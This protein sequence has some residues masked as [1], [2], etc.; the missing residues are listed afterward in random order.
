MN[1]IYCLVFNRSLGVLQAVAETARTHRA[2]GSSGGAAAPGRDPGRACLLGAT[3]L[4]GAL[5]LSLASPPAQGTTWTGSQSDDWSDPDNWTEGVPNPGTGA[6]IDTTGPNAPVLDG[7][8]SAANWLH[9]GT[10]SDGELTI[11]NG[12]ELF[13]QQ[14]ARLGGNPAVSGTVTVSG[15]GSTWTAWDF[16]HI[17]DAGQGWLTVDA[18]GTVSSS[19]TVLGLE[20]S[21]SGTGLVTGAGST[22]QNGTLTVGRWGEGELTVADGGA[23]SSTTAYIGEEIGGQGTVTVTG[24]DSTWTS[25]SLTVGRSG[26]GE[27]AVSD[28]G[29][30]SS[31]TGVVGSGVD[32]IGTATV[33]GTGSEWDSAML[34]VGQYGRGQVTI[35]DEGR[36]SSERGYIGGTAASTSHGTVTVSGVGSTWSNDFQLSVG[37]AGQGGLT[38]EAGGTV[39]SSQGT[40]GLSPG[41]RGT[42]TVSGSG[43]SWHSSGWLFIGRDGDGELTI[44]DGGTVASLHAVIADHGNST[45]KVTVT[46]NASTWVN[47]GDLDVGQ[48][49][50]GELV[51]D[52]GGT[53]TSVGA[54]IGNGANSRGA[55]LVTG[56]N[57]SWHN[58]SLSIGVEGDAVLTI[59]NGGTVHSS[60]SHVGLV[61]GGTGTV[62]VTGTD[63][64][65]E[66]GWLYLAS[67][68]EAALTI[69]DGGRVSTSNGAVGFQGTAS[70]L[71]T[72]PGSTWDTDGMYVG[73]SGE[74]ELSIANGGSVNADGGHVGLLAGSSGSLTVSGSASSFL[75]SGQLVVGQQ[76]NGEL[77]IANGGL[78]VSVNGTIGGHTGAIGTATINGIGSS[79]I[80]SGQF[81][82]G[83][84]GVGGLTIS[85][86]GMLDSGIAAVGNGAG[87]SGTVTVTG[88]GSTW[89]SSSEIRVGFFGQGHL[90][91]SDGGAVDNTHGVIGMLAGSN[92]AVVVTGA[93]STW[94]SSLNLHVGHGGNGEL[95]I[96]DGGTVAASHGQLAT[97]AATTGT[98]NIGAAR[99]AHAVAAGHLNLTDLDLRDGQA[100]VLF[101][102]TDPA[103][104]FTAAMRSVGTGNHAIDHLAGSTTLAADSAGFSGLTTVSGGTLRIAG[105]LGGMAR[106]QDGR[107]QVDGSFGGPVDVQ[108][109]TLAGAGTIGGNVDFDGGTL[110]GVQ[111]QTLAIAGDLALADDSRVHVALG[112]TPASAL[113]DVA[114]DLTLNGSLDISDAGGFGVGLYRLFDYGGT[115]AGAGL[116]LGS[117]PGGIDRDDLSIQTAV[118]GQVNLV[119]LAGAELGFWDGGSAALHHNGVIDG[120]DGTWRADGANWTGMDGTMNGSYRP[121]PTF[122]VFA[123]NAG[124]VV[125]DGS[126]GAIAATGLQFA[127]DG[128]RI[129]GDGVSLSAGA[130]DRIIRV[131]DGSAAGAAFTATIA[132]DLFGTTGLVKTDR[133]TLVLTG[134]NAYGDTH[135]EA[136]TLVGSTASLSGD[137]GNA[138]TVVFDQAGDA[139]FAGDIGD[140][141]GVRGAM[142]KSG[143]GM[144][145]LAGAS[146]LDWSV[147]EGGLVS[148]TSRFGGNLA[149]GAG[150]AF[151]F[152][153][154]ED[155]HYAGTITGA[156]VLGITG[157]GTVLVSG[158]SA[159]Y[160]G[161]T[162]V[163]ASTLLVTGRLGGT[164]AVGDGGVLGGTGTVG[165]TTVGAGGTLSPGTSPGTLTVDGN[166]VLAAGSTYLVEAGP[167]GSH[168][169]VAVTGEAIL[170]GGSVLHLGTASGYAPH[171]TYSILSAAG[172]IQG[173]FG[174]V[175]S[176]F[177]FLDA[178]LHYSADA[179]SLTLERNSVSFAAIG[180]SHNQV[181]IAREA[182]RLGVGHGVFDALVRLDVDAARTAFD[183][184]SGEAHASVRGALVGNA[185]FL[186]DGMGRRL[187]GEAA[188]GAL[189]ADG[190]AA[191]WLSGAG[192]QG[193]SG[194]DGNAAGGRIHGEGLMFGADLAVGD[195][196]RLGAALGSNALVHRNDGRTSR[197]D[198]DGTHFGVYAQGDWAGVQLR[199]GAT[200]SDY[201]V[202]TLRLVAFDGLD[203]RLT[204]GYDARATTVFAEGGYRIGDGARALTPYLGLAHLRLETDAAQESGGDS[205]LALSSAKDEVMTATLGLRGHRSLH[206]GGAARARLQAGLG[207]QHAW[208]ELKAGSRA[209]FAGGGDFTVHGLP[210]ARNSLVMDL[211]V[212]LSPSTRNRLALGLH[213]RVGDDQREYGVQLDWH[214]AF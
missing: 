175:G 116:A 19:N 198:V 23:L 161:L 164:L 148:V 162:R 208:G 184:L 133:G 166:L 71:V 129:E 121:N 87:S 189:H 106:L 12:G 70:A 135:V 202:D 10:L 26:T 111:G 11:R 51:I 41:S 110:A 79:W 188:T 44:H 94:L 112:G 67:Q 18:G 17:G 193:S 57:S 69:A 122:A 78:V 43:S 195:G 191:L 3:A 124:T 177:A 16:L 52:D 141:G 197:A 8:H 59:A 207:W 119:S 13:S 33:S 152:D 123:G 68:G 149:I 155:G 113:F 105:A 157:G 126:A 56:S 55:V 101:N 131:G 107:L 118:A 160:S 40:I 203:D 65:W 2:G 39:T 27:L 45:G 31:T 61:S 146:S 83:L 143:A 151:L 5:A 58:H 179:V 145:T 64:T 138:G 181:A 47:G 154:A 120:G 127:S 77:T 32:G 50:E 192:R 139:A 81:D 187:D 128:Y 150:G 200:R 163:D 93:G 86:G 92:G 34:Y 196:L 210:L 178:S 104:A 167:D 136:G 201:D 97:D 46:G 89:T 115:L 159:G 76:G 36:L 88:S 37:Y 82:V 130:G 173:T 15:P 48:Q 137:I 100:T 9:V 156:G 209:R 172:G 80:N 153:Q 99:N 190:G 204:A 54:Q 185:R 25:A 174:E 114:G 42:A 60:N 213:G 84:G 214:M 62:L 29:R 75:S 21:G 125:V 38:V 158:N 165:T 7:V 205:A 20:A 183:L 30:V 102:H 194:T 74:G 1:R 49:G 35:T 180:Q 24:T 6:A 206:T 170:Q 211:G 4:A 22:W 53:V 98:L 108:G 85:N 134:N 169:L 142:V 14:G 144:L 28:G 90:T 199:G 147:L 73:Y 63:S 182:E 212:E 109:G 132:S 186:R 91:I 176:G 72:G 103:Y 66:T 168:D 171:S 96:A 95:T 117:T 140:F